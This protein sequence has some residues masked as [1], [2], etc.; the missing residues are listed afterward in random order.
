[1]QPTY[2]SRQPAATPSPNPWQLG[3]TASKIARWV[4]GLGFFSAT[5][6]LIA[7]VAAGHVLVGRWQQAD[8]LV[9]TPSVDDE[10]DAS[11]PDEAQQTGKRP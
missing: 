2:N 6:F 4:F 5:S 9:G 8:A 3:P 7:I 1:M 11:S 10:I